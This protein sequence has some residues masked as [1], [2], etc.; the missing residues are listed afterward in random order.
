ME[1]PILENTLTE[2]SGI[3]PRIAYFMDSEVGRC[4]SMGKPISYQIGAL[5]IYCEHVRDLLSDC[6]DNLEIRGQG[7]AV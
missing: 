6:D 5:E 7:K 4:R 2:E 1:G 3:L